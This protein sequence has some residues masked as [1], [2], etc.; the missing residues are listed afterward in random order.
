MKNNASKISLAALALFA[1]AVIYRLM[2]GFV[3]Q[4][5]FGWF[6]NFS[7]LAAI[8]LCGAIYLPRRI[9]FV[10]PLGALLAS[11]LVLN[12]Y[13]GVSLFS[14]EMI[15]RYIVLAGV[16][17]AGLALRSNPGFVKVLFTSIAGSIA[18]YVITNTGSWIG[19]AAYAKTFAG[20][21]QALTVGEPGF[22]P[23]WTFFRN[24]LVSDTLFTAVFVSCMALAGARV[25]APVPARQA[26]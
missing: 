10:L 20:W 3:A 14:A 16:A 5:H 11:D 7:P 2:T 19:D 9:A 12:A 25:I 26:V 15:S 6:S 4:G 17:V 1:V 24:T 23:T 22:A 13:Y 18:F 8:A 21:I